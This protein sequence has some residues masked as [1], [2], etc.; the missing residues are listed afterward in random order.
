MEDLINQRVLKQARPPYFQSYMQQ[1][2]VRNADFIQTEMSTDKSR[3]K[4]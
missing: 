1:H 3:N 2:I 4:A